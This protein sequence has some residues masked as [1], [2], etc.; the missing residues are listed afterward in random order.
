MAMWLIRSIHLDLKDEVLFWSLE[1]GWVDADEANRFTD[2][3]KS[4]MDLP[5]GGE[6]VER[7]P[8]EDSHY[9]EIDDQIADLK[10]LV[11]TL[12][13]TA[14]SLCDAL[15]AT[16]GFVEDTSDIEP[17]H[18]AMLFRVRTLWRNALQQA[19]EAGIQPIS[20]FWRIVKTDLTSSAAI[21]PSSVPINL[22]LRLAAND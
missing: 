21:A 1:D 4:L 11:T 15:A 9:D 18:N 17:E 12:G 5:I 14:H 2:L 10:E 3:E 19:A 16:A 8:L 6:W 20:N 22:N 13:L 7:D